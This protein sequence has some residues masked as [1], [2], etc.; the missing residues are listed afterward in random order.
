MSEQ[1]NGEQQAPTMTRLAPVTVDALLSYAARATWPAGFV[2]YQRG[3][4]AD[5]VFIVLEG[6]VILRSRVRAG[7]GFIPWIATTGETFG[8][9]GLSS[10]PRY[11]TEAR[12]DEA[13]ATLFLSAARYRS[14]LREQPQHA[15]ALVAQMLTERSALLEKLRELTTMSVEQ[16]LVVALGRMA[17]FDSFAG[18]DGSIVLSTNRYRLL[19]ELVGATRE[20]VSL[21]LG[22][23]AADGTIERKGSS[24][25]VRPGQLQLR[26]EDAPLG[27]MLVAD[28]HVLGQTQAI[29]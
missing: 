16:R 28:A 26:T 9:E 3:A 19:C 23:F 21:V 4:Q 11:G 1:L 27:D 15:S 17:T 6:R 29:A 20:S 8:A 2:I 12:A 7:R 13:A 10:T 14:F 22:R 24:L 18:D 25:I 5:G